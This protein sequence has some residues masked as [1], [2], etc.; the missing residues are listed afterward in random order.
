MRRVL[1]LMICLAAWAGPGRAAEPT[2]AVEVDQ[3]APVFSLNDQSGSVRSL[4]ELRKKGPV[5][6]VFYRSAKW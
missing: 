2:K 6:L 4:D 1:F 5:A 3:K